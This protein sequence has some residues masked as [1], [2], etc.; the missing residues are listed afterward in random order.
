MNIKLAVVKGDG[1]GTEIVIEA[2]KVLNKIGEMFGHTF[3][4][5][6]IL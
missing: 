6:D 4:Y 1:I 2:E 3:E 5:T